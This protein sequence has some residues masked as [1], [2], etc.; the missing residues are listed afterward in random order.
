MEYNVRISDRRLVVD[1]S[2]SEFMRYRTVHRYQCRALDYK[3]MLFMPVMMPLHHAV[4]LRRFRRFLNDVGMNSIFA[5]RLLEFCTNRRLLSGIYISDE[6]LLPLM[7]CTAI[8]DVCAD[9]DLIG[10]HLSRPRE[11]TKRINL[12]F[13][14]CPDSFEHFLANRIEHNGVLCYGRNGN[15]DLR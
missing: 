13:A 7:E 15:S 6:L 12:L 11:G 9:I 10:F 2:C 4:L 3:I 14:F 8:D 5:R 1:W